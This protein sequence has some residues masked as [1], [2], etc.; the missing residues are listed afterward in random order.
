MRLSGV[1][2]CLQW[3][4]LEC[5]W[6]LFDST[7]STSGLTASLLST[8]RLRLCCG[9]PPEARACCVPEYVFMLSLVG[10]IAMSVYRPGHGC[11]AGRRSRGLS[12]VH[13]SVLEPGTARISGAFDVLSQLCF[14]DLVV[15]YFVSWQ[16][17]C[18]MHKLYKNY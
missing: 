17:G 13:S 1:L 6:D 3:I 5:V 11:T 10:V 2:T 12:R 4:A 7:S 8:L 14:Y 9:V 18:K 16:L 15:Q